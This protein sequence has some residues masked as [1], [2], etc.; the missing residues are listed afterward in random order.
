MELLRQ[1]ADELLL[2]KISL[3]LGEAKTFE[4]LPQSDSAPG[5]HLRRQSGLP[6]PDARRCWPPRWITG[7]ETALRAQ[8]QLVY[9]GKLTKSGKPFWPTIASEHGRPATMVYAC[10]SPPR[11]ELIGGNLPG[12]PA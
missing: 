6:D 12:I 2:Y 3:W 11:L 1:L 8:Q 10:H 5:G 4:L 7:A 9:R